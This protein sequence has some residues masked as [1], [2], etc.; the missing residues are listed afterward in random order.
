MKRLQE[1][2]IATKCPFFCVVR[3]SL[4]CSL[5]T[6]GGVVDL[7][8]AELKWDSTAQSFLIKQMILVSVLGCY[9]LKLLSFIS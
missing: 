3:C 2:E 7:L 4:L 6:Q 1:K 8:P 5:T 9:V